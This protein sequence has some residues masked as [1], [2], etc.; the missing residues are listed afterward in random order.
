MLL[1]MLLL[2]C[3]LLVVASWKKMERYLFFLLH[4]KKERRNRLRGKILIM[5][6]NITKRQHFVPQFYLKHFVDEQGF[7]HCYKKENRKQFPA[8]TNDVCFKE[9]GY[10]VESS[11]GT[12]KFL[13]PNEI[14]K[15]FCSFEEKYSH[16]LQSVVNKCIRNSDGMAL[17]C[18]LKEKET[19]ASMVANFMTRNFL[20]VDNMVEDKVTQELLHTNQEIIAIDNMLRELK[21]GDAKP[22]LELAQKK[23]FLSPEE[24]GVTKSIIDSLMKMNVSFFVTDTMRFVTSDCP[25]AYNCS[26]EE[27]FMA[28]I[29]LSPKVMVVYTLSETSKPFRNRARLIEKR[30][31]E[32]LNRDY[33]KWDVSQ[34][35]IAKSK[36]DISLL[37]R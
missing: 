30:F 24:N 25:V 8:H 26:S 36:N 12:K 4:S 15:I 16:V 7:L 3:I 21:M 32:S 28:R 14:E 18:T 35:L 34:M 29:P 13:L 33:L 9:Y 10:E 27:L 20:A 23:L 22:F 19:L 5:R 17:I 11:F 31:V 6:D 2:R 1:K 37:L